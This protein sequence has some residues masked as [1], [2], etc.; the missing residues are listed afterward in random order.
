[1]PSRLH[2]AIKGSSLTIFSQDTFHS[3]KN[4]LYFC[5]SCGLAVRAPPLTVRQPRL[6]KNVAECR[7]LALRHSATIR[8]MKSLLSCLSFCVSLGAYRSHEW[9]L[10]P[11]TRI[12]TTARS[13]PFCRASVS[14]ATGKT[15]VGPAPRRR[16]QALRGGDYG[17]V[18]SGKSA[19]SKLVHRVRAQCRSA[20]ASHRCARRRRD[21][22][23]SKM[24]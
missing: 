6:C 14:A 7:L 1:M 8:H 11:S 4:S 13:N 15:A 22:H 17:P 3:W 12:D 10:Q 23:P 5:R 19:E 2:E 16:Q 20:D 24:D 21:R 9:H 18:I